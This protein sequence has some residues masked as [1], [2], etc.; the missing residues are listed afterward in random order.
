MYLIYKDSFDPQN[1][2]SEEYLHNDLLAA[3][4]TK[5]RVSFCD[6]GGISSFS[7][8]PN[9]NCLLVVVLFFRST[10]GTIEP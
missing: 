2:D 5:Y 8:I 1:V 9:G 10:T 7:S 6:D 4:I 3:S